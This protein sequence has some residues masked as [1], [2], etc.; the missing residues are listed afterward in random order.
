M[1]QQ[2]GFRDISWE[3]YE[4]LAN[5]RGSTPRPRM[6]F[7][8]G[9]LELMATSEEHE[10]LK[11][12]LARCVE[13]WAMLTGVV[14]HRAGSYTLKNKRKRAAAEADESYTVGTRH[15]PPDLVIEVML[16]HGTIDKLEIYRRLGVR[17]VWFWEDDALT[18]HCDDGS[19]W[20]ERRTSGVLPDLDLAL[21]ERCVRTGDQAKAL[22]LLT[23]ALK[24]H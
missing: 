7:L 19:R 2:V 4:A 5:K 20:A 8:D 15:Q 14:V 18:V 16:S 1:E 23:S 22:K 10:Y 13:T 21:I 3:Q 12:T 11:A 6:H 24:R 9:A 17:E